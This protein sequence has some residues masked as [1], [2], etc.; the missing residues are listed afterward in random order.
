MSENIELALQL[1]IVGMLSVFFILGIVTGLARMLIL[2]VN[3]F[4]PGH[5]TQLAQ[6]SPSP[7]LREIAILTA[8]VEHIT[9]GKGTIESIKK[10]K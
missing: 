4:A 2:L 10:L 5:H 8:T 1:L 3:K 6:K 9:I 7:S